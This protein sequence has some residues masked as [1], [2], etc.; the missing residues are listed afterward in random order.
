VASSS[1]TTPTTGWTS[2]TKTLTTR[3]EAPPPI[4]TPKSRDGSLNPRLANVRSS[5]YP[6][7][8]GNMPFCRKKRQI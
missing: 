2:L 1:W 8:H 3:I 4:T 6:R 5:F 7:S